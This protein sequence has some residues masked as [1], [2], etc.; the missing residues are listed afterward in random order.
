MILRRMKT[1]QNAKR[2]IWKRRNMMVGGGVIGDCIIC[3]EHA[4]ERTSFVKDCV[5]VFF[6][7]KINILIAIGIVSS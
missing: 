5:F 3:I 1:K 4:V 6:E 2:A 7:I